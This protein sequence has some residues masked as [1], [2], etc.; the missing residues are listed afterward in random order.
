M[1]G[2][3]LHPWMW[4]APENSEVLIVGTFPTAERNRAYDFFYPN[5]ANRFW[6]IMSR[7]SGIELQYF[8][9][10]DAVNERKNI[11]RQL[12][13]AVTDMGK[14]VLRHDGSS[15][16]EKLVP[17]EYM[18]I[19]GIVDKNP[20]ITKLLF[21]SD[22]AAKWFDRYL[23]EKNIRHKFPVAKRPV[24]SV[25]EYKNIKLKLAILYSPS[26]RAASITFEKLVEIYGSYIINQV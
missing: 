11:L 12:K 23:S 25:I 9:G 2:G 17:V 16:D 19:L 3:E 21:T 6:K 8:A 1:T 18:D 20:R 4:F 7:L 13:V 10:N 24:N 5:I 14:T 26:P 15:L 22:K